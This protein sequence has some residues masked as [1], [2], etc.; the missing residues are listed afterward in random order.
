MLGCTKTLHLNADSLAQV[1]AFGYTGGLLSAYS[2]QRGLL[3]LQPAGTY[4]NASFSPSSMTLGGMRVSPGVRIYERLIG[5]AMKA[6]S[7]TD[8]PASVNVSQYH[9]D[10]SGQVDLIIIG[11]YSGD[12]VEYG[13]IDVLNGY[14]VEEIVPEVLPEPDPDDPEG[15]AQEP[16]APIYRRYS[17][18][19]VVYN[20]TEYPVAQG[21]YLYSGYARLSLNDSGEVAYA[22]YLRAI[23]NVPSS[24]FYTQNGVTYVRTSQGTFQVDEGVQ[25]YNIA[26]SYSP[27]SYPPTWV[28]SSMW[29]GSEWQ[30]YWPEGWEMEWFPA[31]PTIVKFA[32]LSECRNF[33]STLTLYVDSV[34]Q[35]VRVIEAS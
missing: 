18:Q 26:A 25:C 32:D 10:G 2:S 6:R 30:G 24:A 20:G 14:R 11:S 15:G 27:S 5:G 16:Q 7:L 1:Q 33:A 4:I 28:N 8:L 9:L 3:S 29:S 22:S 19:K 35:R 21:Q 34:G 12:G 13:R 23:S 31:A 17:V